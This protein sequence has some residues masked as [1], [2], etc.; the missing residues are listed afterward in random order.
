MFL[1]TPDGHNVVLQVVQT[2]PECGIVQQATIS[3]MYS[4]VDGAAVYTV[5]ATTPT[6]TNQQYVAHPY[7]LVYDGTTLTKVIEINGVFH[8]QVFL[9]TTRRRMCP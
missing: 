3:G 2:T 9:R 8:E 4:D 5:A 1:L 6:A 7:E